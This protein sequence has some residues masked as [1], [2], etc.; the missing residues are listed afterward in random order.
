MM[1]EIGLTAEIRHADLVAGDVISLKQGKIVPLDSPLEFA[2][3]IDKVGEDRGQYIASVVPRGALCV[4]V[5]GLSPDTRQ[6]TRVFAL[7]GAQTVTLA[8]QGVLI[9]EFL[10]LGDIER[11]MAIVGFRRPTDA[12]RFE[13]GGGRTSV[14]GTENF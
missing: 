2:G 13:L 6:G 1:L 14:R 7:P 4:Q 9:G 11:G 8:E 10:A 3:V 12:R 5:Q